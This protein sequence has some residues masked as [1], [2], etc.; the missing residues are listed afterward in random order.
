MILRL[1]LAF[2]AAVV[3]TAA[4]A[5]AASTQ[6]VLAELGRLGVDIGIGDR[7]AMTAY[8]VLGMGMTYL[9]VV[10]VGFLLGFGVAALVLHY[11]LPG[12]PMLGYS[13][14]GFTA[15]LAIILIMIAAFGLVPIAGARSMTGMFSQCLAGAAGGY[16]FARILTWNRAA[17]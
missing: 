16:V 8:D 5:A 1:I 17:A 7:L 13:L 2:L 11:L 14:A 3:V 10:G 4:L 9:P 15:I 12:W 6:F